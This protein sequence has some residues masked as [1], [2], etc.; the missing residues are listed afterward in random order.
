MGRHDVG[1]DDLLSGDPFPKS[2]QLARGERRYRRKV[3]SPKQWQAIR[4][5]KCSGSC[6]V[7]V[8]G[9]P[10]SGHESHH[11]IPR[12]RHGDDVADNIIGLCASCHRDVEL[13]EAPMC[14][15]L[16]SR[17]TD[18]EYT[19]AVMRAGENFAERVYGITYTR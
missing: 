11:L 6:R 9:P 10:S 16:L 12:D 7:C 14:R 3:A 8:I 15:V 1:R 5:A 4:A 19:Y 2:S 13:R 17:L 18:A